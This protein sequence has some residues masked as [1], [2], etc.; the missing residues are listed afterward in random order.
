MSCYQP[1]VLCCAVPDVFPTEEI[2]SSASST[3]DSD[4]LCWLS[5]NKF[6]SEAIS[7]VVDTLVFIDH[8]NIYM[9]SLNYP[10]IYIYIQR[11]FLFNQVNFLPFAF[12]YGTC[13]NH[14]NGFVIYVEMK[15]PCLKGPSTFL[16]SHVMLVH[17]STVIC[18]R[19]FITAHLQACHRAFPDI[20]CH[21]LQLFEIS[22]T[23]L[24]SFMEAYHV[25]PASN[26]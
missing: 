10:Y 14:I 24:L 7:K 23:A 26:V 17:G 6:D 16:Y 20:A 8:P 18:R 21:V 15:T 19:I 12:V 1:F 25:D 9:P 2:T 5:E 22:C 11:A 3:I 13:V 4:L